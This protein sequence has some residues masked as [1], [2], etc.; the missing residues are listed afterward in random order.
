LTWRKNRRGKHGGKS[1]PKRQRCYILGGR[2][3][4]GER[5]VENSETVRDGQKGSKVLGPLKKK[6]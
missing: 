1:S 4:L 2:P 6:T 5:I 3:D